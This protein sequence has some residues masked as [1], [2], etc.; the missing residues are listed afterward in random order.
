VARLAHGRKFS[1]REPRGFRGDWRICKEDRKKVDV[2]CIRFWMR[3]TLGL[4]KSTRR[5]CPSERC[6]KRKGRKAELR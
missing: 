3:C 6:A 4:V 2:H 1:T 5:T